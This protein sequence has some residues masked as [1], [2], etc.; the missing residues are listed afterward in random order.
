MNSIFK[1]CILKAIFLC[2]AIVCA[3]P[4]SAYAITVEITALVPGCGDGLIGV[5][6]QCDGS[7]LGGASCS[8]LGFRS[9]SVSCSAT[10]MYVTESCTVGSSGG[11]GGG[12]GGSS[13]QSGIPNTNVVFTGRAYPRSTVTLLKDAQVVATTVASADANFQMTISNISS[14]NYIFSVYSEDSKGIRSSLLTFPVGIT[15]GVTTKVSDIFIAPSI[16]TDKSEVRRGDTI[17]IFGQSIPNAQVTIQVNSEH[18]HFIQRLA[19]PQ[20]VYLVNFDTSV[21]E[22]GQHS[23]RSKA[24][25]DNEISS[26]SKI[27]GFI[28]GNRNVAAVLDSTKKKG[29][30]NNDTKVNLIDFSIAAFWYKRTLSVIFAPIEVDHLNGDGIIDLR[31]FSIIAYNWTG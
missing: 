23:T 19:D 22:N 31:D 30:L 17:S 12:G 15:S 2:T 16:A 24:A 5:G 18:E 8:S 28:V 29:D 26:F 21:L 14:G 27:V 11:G 13:G 1:N 9:G 4:L 25:L 10:C 3:L 6:E 7:N 20:G